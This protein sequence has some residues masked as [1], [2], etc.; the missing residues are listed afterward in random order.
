MKNCLDDK[1]DMSRFMP[2]PDD[3][4]LMD[5]FPDKFECELCGNIIKKR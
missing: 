2:C 4:M 5:E 3:G 1:I